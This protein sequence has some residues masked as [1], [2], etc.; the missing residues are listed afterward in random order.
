MG[1]WY[2][3]MSS[4][5]WL[6]QVRANFRSEQIYDNAH[7]FVLSLVKLNFLHFW[8]GTNRIIAADAQAPSL[9]FL[10]EDLCSKISISINSLE[11]KGGHLNIMTRSICCFSQIIPLITPLLCVL[12]ISPYVDGEKDHHFTKFRFCATFTLCWKSHSFEGKNIDKIR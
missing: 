9:H 8:R 10:T 1:D 7:F 5:V 4:E 11:L 12:T 3:R 2:T 6:R